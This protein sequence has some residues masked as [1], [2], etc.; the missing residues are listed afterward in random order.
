MNEFK[1]QNSK[2]KYINA[3]SSDGSKIQIKSKKFIFCTG[4]I[5]TTRLLLLLDKQNNKIISKTTNVLEDIF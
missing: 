4:A 1:V 2:L 5:E 3:I